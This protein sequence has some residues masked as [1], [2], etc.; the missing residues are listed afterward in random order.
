VIVDSSPENCVQR[1]LI[2]ELVAKHRLPAI[3]GFRDFVDVGG[4][5]S[6]GVDFA[7]LYR[8]AADYADLIL[9][10]TLPGDIPVFQGTKFSLIINLR[11]A[12]ASGLSLPATM[13]AQADDV[14]E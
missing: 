10:G 11:V 13:L 8:H 4:L 12:R 6:H 9:R 5:V 1:K 14:L 2:V 3:Y 7:E